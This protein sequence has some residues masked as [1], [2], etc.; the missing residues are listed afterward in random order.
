VTNGPLLEFNSGADNPGQ[1]CR[2]FVG[3]RICVLLQIFIRRYQSYW[4]SHALRPFVPETCST[5]SESVRIA[6]DN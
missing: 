2:S 6:D 5:E 3:K 4:C 1:N